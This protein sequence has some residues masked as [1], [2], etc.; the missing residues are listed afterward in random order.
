MDLMHHLV[1]TE[2]LRENLGWSE[3]RRGPMLLGTIGPDA[4]TEVPGVGREAMHPGGDPV[5]A[6]MEMMAPPGCLDG[7]EGRGFAV[8]AIGHLIADTMTRRN[9]YHLPPHAPTG[10]AELEAPAEKL[11]AHRSF[12]AEAIARALMR[13]EV[14]CW[15]QPLEPE[16][17]D[18]KRWELLGRFP[19]HE[20]GVF[21]VVEPLA[22]VARLCAGRIAARLQSSQAAARLVAG[23]RSR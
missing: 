1:V 18:G 19:L 20:G 15:L 7:D 21:E 23:A 9:R 3:R 8:S 12:D 13:A 17:I 4:H 2:R 14:A 22:T 11:Q 6:V 16:A 10:F 5:A